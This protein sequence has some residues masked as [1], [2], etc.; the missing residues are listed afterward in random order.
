MA[1]QGLKLIAKVASFAL[2]QSICY[3]KV[4]EEF[5]KLIKDSCTI[6]I[7]KFSRLVLCFFHQGQEI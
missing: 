2:S 3:K 4:K 5:Q 1:F 6:I 7:Q